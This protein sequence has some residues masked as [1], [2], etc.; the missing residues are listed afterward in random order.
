LSYEALFSVSGMS[1]LE[2]LRVLVRLLE[3]DIITLAPG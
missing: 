1:R 3:Q 2:T